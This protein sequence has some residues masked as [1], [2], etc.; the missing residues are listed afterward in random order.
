MADEPLG[1]SFR[2]P[3]GFV[4]ERD[5][6]LHRQVNPR[7][8]PD[9]DHLVES[10][11]YR[12][13][14][15]RNL[16]IPHEEARGEPASRGEAHRILRP[17]R[18]DFVSYPYEW[19]FSQLQD[20]A[21]ATLQV[22]QLALRFDMTLKDA[23]AYNVQFHRGRPLWIDTLSFERYRE[24]SPW[25]G[26]RQF[27]QHFLAPLALMAYRDVRLSSLLRVHLDGIPLDLARSLL[28]ARAWLNV[29]LFLH[30][31]MHAGYQQRYRSDTDA[32]AKVR[33]LSKSAHANLI[34]A[35]ESAVKR[36]RWRADGTEWADYAAGVSYAPA[37]H[38]HKQRLVSQ[39]LDT[40][41][42]GRVWDLGANTGEFSR[43]A[44]ER[45]IQT[46]SFDKDPACI[47]RSYRRARDTGE[48][49][50]LPLV[51][52]LTN[53][54]PALGWAHAERASLADRASADALL[55]LA[56]VHHLA[57][58]NNVPLPQVAS[59]FAD[60]AEGLIVEFVPKSDPRVQTMLATREDVF[61]DYSRNG[62]EAA[63][64]TRFTLE[65]ATPLVG[66]ERV[67]YR[68]R[69]R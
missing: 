65:D 5:G 41:A 21:L 31:R 48:S 32:A 9:Y 30:I 25:V 37:S 49:K 18:V 39:H 8:A 10:G 13:L 51:L 63:F 6:I 1:S 44:S 57:I 55:A 69:R 26:Y 40:L 67:V 62:F 47:D 53:P 56:L 64:A 33:P 19:S 11:L 3:S 16:L 45:G 50:L 29:H 7:Y 22:Q 54:S 14:T 58:G 24:G 46:I 12:E 52:D 42:P 35:L 17:E 66:S 34:R 36:L 2:D 43:I 23:S 27:C 28:P 61:P 38:E 59:F 20:A 15:E 68:M 4:F 60:L